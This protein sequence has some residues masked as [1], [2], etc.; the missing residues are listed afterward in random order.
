MKTYDDIQTVERVSEV[1]A[2]DLMATHV[3]APGEL[4]RASDH[5]GGGIDIVWYPD[6]CRAGI[7]WGADAQWTD[8]DSVDDALRRFFGVNG[9]EMVN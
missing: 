1:S 5:S 8:A 7:A 4:W 9:K 2:I 6:V 3:K